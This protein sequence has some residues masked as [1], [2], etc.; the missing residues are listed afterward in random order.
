MI[1]VAESKNE[2]ILNN[3]IFN[4]PGILL[5]TKKYHRVDSL[6]EVYAELFF[7]PDADTLLLVSYF[8]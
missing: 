8:H 1:E 7:N 4:L 3:F 2:K 5:L 6:C